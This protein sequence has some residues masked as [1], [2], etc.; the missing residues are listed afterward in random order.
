MVAHTNPATSAAS[1]ETPY[2]DTAV[3]VSK[4]EPEPGRPSVLDE[5]IGR[6]FADIADEVSRRSFEGGQDA[7]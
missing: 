3:L 7:P 5:L 4:P 6:T 1:R 2:S